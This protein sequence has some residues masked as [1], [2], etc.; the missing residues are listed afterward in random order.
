[1]TDLS[2]EYS[3][4]RSILD[5]M[6]RFATS[7][8]GV[9]IN[10]LKDPMA[11]LLL[12]CLAEEVYK[13]SGEFDNMEDRI[14]D[15]LSDM[16]VSDVKAIAKPAHAVL[17]ARP[18]ESKC[19]ITDRASFGLP[20][21]NHFTFFPVCNTGLFKGDIRYFAHKGLFYS[22]DKTQH[23]TLLSRTKRTSE[24]P[25]NTFWIGLEMDE[26]IH[27]LEGLSFYIDFLNT[28]QKM[29]QLSLLPYCV[30]NIQDSE[31]P[32]SRGI[33][34]KKEE[35]ANHTLELFAGYDL[36]HKVNDCIKKE[37]DPYFL[38]VGE[39]F[40]ITDKRESFPEK[41]KEY[42]TQGFLE[43]FK[44]PLVWIEVAC[45]GEITHEAITSI[46]ISINAFP[47]VCKRLVSKTVGLN[48]VVP[49]IPLDTGNDE[50]FMSVCSL[51]DSTGK[52]YYDIPF[53]DSDAYGIYA[54]RRGGCERYNKREAREYLINILTRMAKEASLF[55]SAEADEKNDREQIQEDIR[56]LLKGLKT[57]VVNSKDRYEIKNYMLL[58]PQINDKNLYFV[59]YWVTVNNMAENMNQ[60]LPM[61]AEPGL[62]LDPGSIVLMSSVKKGK[63]TPG[64][65][66][67][68]KIYSKSITD[69]RILVT[70]DDIKAFCLKEFGDSISEVHI[71]KGLIESPDP[72]IG[73][74][75]T[76]DVYLKPHKGLNTYIGQRDETYFCELLK[77]NSPFTFRYR[78]FIDKT[79][80]N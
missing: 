59:S 39:S 43:D 66:E 4:K 11:L 49:I 76:T 64:Q 75:R 57:M 19:L 30:W 77:K 41:L 68:Y 42:Y 29:N 55:M 37:Y 61:Q 52:A 58:S 50:S 17:H 70:N 2:T 26:K 63:G 67:K 18:S 12:E 78:V 34:A 14:L 33:P 53:K 23:K 3:H 74:I 20:A 40:D 1:M 28:Y 46:R 10:E 62:Q 25:D 45:P 44:K 80:S 7:H 72:A 24:F 60:G 8:I 71:C 31:L 48:R 56:L 13:I 16:L 22:I 21:D 38:H 9:K 15:K 27:D 54:L 5:R 73:F 32:V 6:T 35:Y 36:S 47:V 69:S 79:R 51:S 65:S